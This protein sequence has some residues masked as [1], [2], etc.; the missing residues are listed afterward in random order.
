M[1]FA[2]FAALSLAVFFGHMT[3]A[4]AALADEI[5]ETGATRGGA[6]AADEPGPSL[7][8]AVNQD[9]FF[10]F[11]VISQVA[12]P[13][14]DLIDLTFYGIQW[15]RPG[16][17]AGGGG[18]DLWT[19]WGLGA[20][21]D[22]LEGD[23]SINPQFGVLNGTL[24]SGSNR[25]FVF[26][27]VV[28]NLT[29]TYGGDLFEGQIYAGFYLATR[30][31]GGSTRNDFIHYWVNAGVIVVD[32]LSAGVHWEHLVQTRGTRDDNDVYQWIGPYLEAKA[33]VGFLRFVAGVDVAPD[34]VSD[35]YKLIVGFTL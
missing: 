16:F 5:E 29:A 3:L 20:S 21:F 9:N 33:D 13:L 8:V 28:P 15:T 10:G 31:Q 32:W 35:F 24:L 6:A 23:L 18:A 11:H 4:S 1:I 30:D 27:G 2:R 34:D 14:G 26:E 7:S 25:A 17:G 22:L 19:E 12:I